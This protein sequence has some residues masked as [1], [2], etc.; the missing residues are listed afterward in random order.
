MTVFSLKKVYHVCRYP[1]GRHVYCLS[2]NVLMITRDV[3][4]LREKTAALAA[5]EHYSSLTKHLVVIVLNTSKNRYPPR[6]VSGSLWIIPTNSFSIFFAVIHALRIT[7][8]ELFFQGKLQVDV[9]SAEDAGASGITAWLISLLYNRPYQMHIDSNVL[10]YT[11]A[12]QSIGHLLHMY[13]A[14]YLTYK[15]DSLHITSENVR[16]TLAD[17]STALADR[18]VV[19]QRYMDIEAFQKEPVHVDLSAKYPQFKTILLVVAPLI[20]SSNVDRAIEV[21]AGVIREFPYAG[22]VIVGEGPL[23][24]KL[25]RRASKIDVAERVAFEAHNDNITSYYKTAR[26][27]VQTA[28]YMEHDE[29]VIW[30]AASSCAIVS[31]KS[32]SAEAIL[33]DGVSGFLCDEYDTKRFVESIVSM[34]KRPELANQIRLNANIAVQNY[35]SNDLPSH[36]ESYKKSWEQA[37]ASSSAPTF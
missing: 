33:T 22:L 21:L 26:F 18:A 15:A 30:A 32:G 24:G 37:I 3:N 35:M 25:R 14:R 9:L 27:Y 23:E 31:T 17:M 34:I 4:V 28:S 1:H 5:V 8:K 10:T 36:L 12:R 20:R 7:R 29:S 13:V 11:Y 6:K 16:A 2:M 19:G